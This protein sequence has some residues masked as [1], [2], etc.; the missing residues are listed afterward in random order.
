MRIFL[1]SKV[2]EE[3]EEEGISVRVVGAIPG[4]GTTVA[5]NVALTTPSPTPE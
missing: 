5:T 3:E 4:S 1:I 2:D